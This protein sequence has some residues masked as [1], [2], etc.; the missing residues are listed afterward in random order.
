MTQDDRE[1][2]DIDLDELLRRARGGT[3]PRVSGGPLIEL[4][5]WRGYLIGKAEDLVRGGVTENRALRPDE[6]RSVSQLI[7]DAME[8]GTMIAELH[9]AYRRELSDPSNL[10]EISPR[11][12]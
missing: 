2:K 3:L 10:V 5:R 8:L 1:L 7:D 11:Y 4:R 9:A 6:D 12:S